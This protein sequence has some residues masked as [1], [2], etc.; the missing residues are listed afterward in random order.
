MRSTMPK[1]REIFGRILG[2]GFPP[3]ELQVI[4]MVIRMATCPQFELDLTVLAAHGDAVREGKQALLEAAG[5]TGGDVLMLR[6][7]PRLA[8]RLRSLGVQ[9]PMKISKTTGHRNFAFAKTDKEFTDLRRHKDPKVSTLIDARLA[10]KSTI[11][12]SRTER[13]TSI[14]RLTDMLPVPLNY[15]G[16]H[17]IGSAV[18]GRSTCR[19]CPGKA[20]CAKRYALHQVL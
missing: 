10:H 15:S 8:E 3:R 2:E 13:L 4:D 19:T 12:E 1:C 17:T 9:V 6:S 11:E 16:A 7:D 18:R 20:S 14:G 5:L